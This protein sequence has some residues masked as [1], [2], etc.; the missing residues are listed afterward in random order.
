MATR[1]VFRDEFTGTRIWSAALPRR[2]VVVMAKKEVL[3][4]ELT[5][6]GADARGTR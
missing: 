1:E 2:F 5:E 4:D 6:A 3:R